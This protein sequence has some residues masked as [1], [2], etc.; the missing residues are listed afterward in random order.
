MSDDWPETVREAIIWH[1]EAEIAAIR[2]KRKYEIAC[3]DALDRRKFPLPS[4]TTTAVA[5]ETAAE[6][7]ALDDAE[8]EE[9]KRHRWLCYVIERGREKR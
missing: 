4:G 7:S 2:A 6:R 8:L 9:G 3:E 5:R 1:H